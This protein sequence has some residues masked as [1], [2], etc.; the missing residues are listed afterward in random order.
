[1]H[2]NIR[3]LWCVLVW[4]MRFQARRF[5]IPLCT[6]VAQVFKGS[7]GPAAAAAAGA[8]AAAAAAAVVIADAR[9][10]AHTLDKQHARA[11]SIL[12]EVGLR[13]GRRETDLALSFTVLAQ[14]LVGKG[15]YSDGTLLPHC[16]IPHCNIEQG[17]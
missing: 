12:N 2:A 11:L 13:N 17:S 1:M 3:P 6:Q 9:V 10:A 14:L 4:H 16:K 8:A 5:H 7:S 15:C